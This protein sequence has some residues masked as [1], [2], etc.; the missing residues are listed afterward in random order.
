MLLVVSIVFFVVY[1]VSLGTIV[2]VGL[3]RQKRKERRHVV[4]VGIN[5]E[6]VVVLIPFRNEEKRLEPLLK[7]LKNLKRYPGEF[8]FI[9]DHSDDRSVTMIEAAMDGCNYSILPLPA[10]VEGKKRALRYAIQ[11]TE[12]TWIL[13]MDADIHVPSDYFVNLSRMERADMYVLPAIMEPGNWMEH[14]YAIDLYLVNAVNAGL[15]GLARPIVASGANLLYSRQTF[16]LVDNFVSHAHAASGDDTYLLRDFRL[17]LTDVRVSTDPGLAVFTETPH[18]LK[19]LIDQRLRWIGKTGNM[20][21]L[22]STLLGILQV[23]LTAGFI[24]LLV[25]SCLQQEWIMSL[26]IWVL[27]T[28]IDMTLFYGF[29]SRTRRVDSWWFIP[30]YELVFPFYSLAILVLMPIYKPKWKGRAIYA[31]KSL[32]NQ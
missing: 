16:H 25:W 22:L 29:F 23:S 1:T 12:S 24:A 5:P 18:S 7:S 11:H 21:D 31:G 3:Q 10:G 27:K 6:E 19:E 20:K 2:A 9:D 26:A 28:L 14:F 4:P 30:L 17:N 13:T 8:V 15:S 32:A